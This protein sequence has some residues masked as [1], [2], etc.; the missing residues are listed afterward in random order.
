MNYQQIGDARAVNLAMRVELRAQETHLKKAWHS[1]ESYFR[2]K[3][4]RMM[5][6]KMFAEWFG[7]KFL[8]LVWGNGES[9]LKLGRSIL[10]IFLLMQA[11]MF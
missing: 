2:L 1:K 4:K 3:Y 6:A 9:L 10:I 7:F 11:T 5:R 8:D